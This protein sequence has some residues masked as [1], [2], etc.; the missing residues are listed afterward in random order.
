MLR[1]SPLPQRPL[2]SMCEALWILPTIRRASHSV[3]AVAT[4]F[5]VRGFDQIV[6]LHDQPQGEFLKPTPQIADLAL[7]V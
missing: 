3:W 6:K 7:K 1:S 4:C 2:H 5:A